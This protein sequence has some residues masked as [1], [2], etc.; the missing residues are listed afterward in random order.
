MDILEITVENNRD[1]TIITYKLND[2]IVDILSKD[3]LTSVLSRLP[4]I[5]LSVNNSVSG[6]TNNT[7]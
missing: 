5:N 2:D 7:E 3:Q 6:T 1:D 4:N